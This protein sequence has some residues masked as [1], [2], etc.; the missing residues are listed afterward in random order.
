MT[1]ERFTLLGLSG[2][3]DPGPQPPC[4]HPGPGVRGE[5]GSVVGPLSQAQGP[6][7][8]REVFLVTSPRGWMAE[9]HWGPPEGQAGAYLT[10]LGHGEATSKPQAYSLSNCFQQP[11]SLWLPIRRLAAWGPANSV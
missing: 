8:S 6:T 7:T 9:E 11:S 5:A 4:E 1:S 10:M 3:T 2:C